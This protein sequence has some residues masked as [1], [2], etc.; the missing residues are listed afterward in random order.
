MGRS[1]LG[2]VSLAKE[3]GEMVTAKMYVRL[4]KQGMTKQEIADMFG[5][6]RAQLNNIVK[7]QG[8]EDGEN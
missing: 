5:V 4:R 3:M 6:S 2:R 7:N 8:G 1:N